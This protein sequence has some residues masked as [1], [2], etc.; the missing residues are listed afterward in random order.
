MAWSR[1]K[2]PNVQWEIILP[3]LNEETGKRYEQRYA[4]GVGGAGIAINKRVSSAKKDKLIELVN[5][6]YSEE[7]Q[8][9]TQFGVEGVTYDMVDGKPVFKD[10]V[11]NNPKWPD[12][13]TT[14]TYFGIEPGT[15]FAMVQNTDT[16]IFEPEAMAG[17]ALYEAN[18]DMFENLLSAPPE[19]LPLCYNEDESE[20]AS[21]NYYFV[22]EKEM[23][24]T[25]E[26]I[27]GTRPFSE[28]DKF[29]GEL[30][31]YGIE[32]AIAKIDAAYQRSLSYKNN[33]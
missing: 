4:T 15:H 24:G 30:K 1:I 3:P 25:Y 23:A 12:S 20:A 33:G 18:A 17:V 13:L 26:F 9:L 31:S 8:L 27:R 29:M 10:I 28:W 19:T 14:K 21:Y 6:L 5:Y 11:T 22:Q 32:Q 7:G 2:D 16:F